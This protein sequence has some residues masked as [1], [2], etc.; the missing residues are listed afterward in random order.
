[1]KTTILIGALLAVFSVQSIAQT[2]TAE[3]TQT[4]TSAATG[5]AVNSGQGNGNSLTLNSTYP[6][7]TRETLNNV[8]APVL[9]SYAGSFSQ[10]NCGQTMQAG[11]AVAGFSAVAG[12]SHDSKTCVLEVAAQETMK[13]STVTADPTEKVALQKASV[14]IRCQVSPEVYQAYKAAGLDCLGLKPEGVVEESADKNIKYVPVYAV[15]QTK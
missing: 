4:T 1:M 9:G 12:A 14:A 8:S 13:Q 2:A 6:S 5:S 15:A 11:V 10:L 7:A 3:Q